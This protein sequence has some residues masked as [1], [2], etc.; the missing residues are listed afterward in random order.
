VQWRRRRKQSRSSGRG[1]RTRCAR[2]GYD[3]EKWGIGG[4]EREEGGRSPAERVFREGRWKGA[5]ANDLQRNVE[6][7]EW[8]EGES[9]I[10]RMIQLREKER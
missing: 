6:G 9:E 5:R 8:G 2:A 7:H 4:R 3:K 1:A 10:E